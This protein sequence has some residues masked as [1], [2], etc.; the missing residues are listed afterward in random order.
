MENLYR[1][2]IV[3][4][5]NTLRQKQNPLINLEDFILND[6]NFEVKINGNVRASLAYE[7]GWIEKE[8]YIKLVLG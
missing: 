2:A 3:F 8:D 6:G 4:Y 1:K 7:K 5:Y